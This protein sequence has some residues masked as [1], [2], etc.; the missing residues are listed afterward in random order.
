[1]LSHHFKIYN[2]GQQGM[3]S[4]LSFAL[5]ELVSGLHLY[6]NF[7]CNLEFVGFSQCAAESSDLC[8]LDYL[9]VTF[10]TKNGHCFMLTPLLLQHMVLREE[11]FSTI[12]V[13]VNDMIEDLAE[14]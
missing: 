6:G 14:E 12:L 1:M 11:H 3:G 8:S 9:C 4:E 13:L 5:D 10:L 7:N 2:L